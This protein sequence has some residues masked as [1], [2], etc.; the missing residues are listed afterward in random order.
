MAKKNQGALRAAYEEWICRICHRR[1]AGSVVS[2][3]VHMRSRECRAWSD[4][5]AQ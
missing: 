3:L 4:T 5:E 1:G 2:L